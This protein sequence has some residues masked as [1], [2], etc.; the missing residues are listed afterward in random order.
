MILLMKE[1]ELMEIEIEKDGPV[2]Q[3]D[4]LVDVGVPLIA[5]IT[6]RSIAELGIK[7]GKSVYALV[8]S[9]AIDRP[10]GSNGQPD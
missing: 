1:H 9:A 5:R 8:K 2:S 7:P 3:A 4:V 6:R 10:G